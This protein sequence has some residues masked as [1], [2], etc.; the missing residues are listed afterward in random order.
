M[1][2]SFMSNQALIYLSEKV[3]ELVSAITKKLGSH[4]Q[5]FLAFPNNAQRVDFLHI[6]KYL[7]TIFQNCWIE[8]PFRANL[9]FGCVQGGPE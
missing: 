5:T 7:K 3:L 1:F 4:S 9:L 8:P 6:S 2:A